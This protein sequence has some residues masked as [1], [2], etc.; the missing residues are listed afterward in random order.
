MLVCC[1]HKC[2][3]LESLGGGEETTTPAL[4]TPPEVDFYVSF[5]CFTR[6]FSFNAQYPEYNS[7]TF[8]VMT[9]KGRVI[10]YE[11]NREQFNVFG[12]IFYWKL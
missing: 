5:H 1:H 4:Y 12:R 3:E 9:T 2:F 6:P 7:L 10:E 8:P 11:A